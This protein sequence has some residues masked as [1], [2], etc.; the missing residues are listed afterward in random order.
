MDVYGLKN[1]D[2]CRKATKALDAAGAPYAFH[3]LKREPVAKSKIDKWAG[4]VGWEALL[5][6]RSTTWRKLGDD[7]KQDLTRKRAV[8]LMEAHQTLMKRPIIEH[9]P[10]Q[11]FVGWTSKTQRAALG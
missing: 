4:A 3:D 5:N 10:T 8:A 1:C 11:V 7:D 9:G 6:K 2:T